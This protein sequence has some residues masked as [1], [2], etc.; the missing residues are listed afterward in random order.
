MRRIARRHERRWTLQRLVRSALRNDV[1]RSWRAISALHFRGSP[2]TLSLAAALCRSTSWRHRELGCN[3]A[4]QLRQRH[5]RDPI[6]ST[7]YAVEETQALLLTGLQYRRDEVVRAA[8][9]GVGHRSFD[10]ALPELVRLSTHADPQTRWSVAAAL[11]RY[12]QPAA[13]EALL[14][15]ARDDDADVRDWATFGLG[16]MSDTDSPEIRELLWHNLADDDEDVRG[17]A[18]VGLAKRH[19]PR[20]VDAVLRALAG[21]VRVYELMAAGELAS[22]SLLDGLLALHPTIADVSTYWLG[23]LDD[24]IT[25]CTPAE[26][27]AAP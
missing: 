11:G 9:A 15:L 6:A 20:A 21:E 4:A 17:E 23:H 19:D 10:A 25:A 8:V 18:L 16:T 7:E 1:D 22:P 26:S 2:R 5:G 14:R 13:I 27:T 3:I 12:P 24:A